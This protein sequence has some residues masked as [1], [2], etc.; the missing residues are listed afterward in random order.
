MIRWGCEPAVGE[1]QKTGDFGKKTTKKRFEQ[2]WH[3]GK[4]IRVVDINIEWWNVSFEVS[5]VI[6]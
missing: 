4:T 1:K 5:V 2:Q 6:K 3:A